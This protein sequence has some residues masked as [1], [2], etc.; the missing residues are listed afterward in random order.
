MDWLNFSGIFQYQYGHRVGIPTNLHN[1]KF[2][3][4][5]SMKFSRPFNRKFKIFKKLCINPQGT[6]SVNK[7]VGKH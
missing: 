3:L 1:M 2:S 4:G 6:E 5:D 7:E